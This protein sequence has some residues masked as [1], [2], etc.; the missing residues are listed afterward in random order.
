MGRYSGSM[1]GRSWAVINPLFLLSIYVILYV[2]ILRVRMPASASA[3][4]FE[5]VLLIFTGLIPWLGVSEGLSTSVHSVV[6]NAN[7]VHN[8]AFPAAVLPAKAVFA[9][10]AG[11]TIGLVILLVMLACTNHLSWTWICLPLAIAAQILFSLGL[12]WLLSVLNVF[13]RDLGQALPTTL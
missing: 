12:A 10:L 11:Q 8:T 3:S 6:S 5:Y 13:I 7:L 9:S 1:L 4:P 2:Y